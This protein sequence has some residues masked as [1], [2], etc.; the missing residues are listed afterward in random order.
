[1][2]WAAP[3]FGTVKAE[4]TMAFSMLCCEE[5]MFRYPKVAEPENAEGYA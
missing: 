3:P 5:P 4:P 2:L 1:M